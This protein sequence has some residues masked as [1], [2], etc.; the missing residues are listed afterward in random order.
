[1][2]KIILYQNYSENN[3]VDKS[4]YIKKVGELEGTAREGFSITDFELTIEYD[5]VPNFNYIYID[6]FKRYYFITDFYNETNKIWI[7]RATVD[8]LMTYKEGI[9]NTSAF[10]DR[11]EYEYTPNII[12]DKIVISQ[13]YDVSTIELKN[14][15]FTDYVGSYLITGLGFNIIER[16]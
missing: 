11:N 9:L 16:G 7:I 2:F 5:G 6:E 15:L 4:S 10:I 14:A 8:V 1:M 3:R 13:G 12:D